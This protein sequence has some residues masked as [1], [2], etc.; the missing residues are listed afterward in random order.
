MRHRAVCGTSENSVLQSSEWQTGGAHSF[1]VCHPRSAV[2]LHIVE[3]TLEQS[4]HLAL[5][6]A[7]C[8]EVVEGCLSKLDAAERLE[9]DP[10]LE[11]RITFTVFPQATAT[12]CES[13]ETIGPALLT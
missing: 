10:L 6:A 1:A 5:Q 11:T 3:L 13:K 7:E 8:L 12:A 2:Y 9:I 4:V